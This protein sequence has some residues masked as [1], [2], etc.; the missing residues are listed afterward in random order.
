MDSGGG[1][2][3]SWTEIVLTFLGW[4]D[5]MLLVGCL[6]IGCVLKRPWMMMLFAILLSAVVNFVRNPLVLLFGWEWL[7][8]HAI[9]AMICT[10][11]VFVIAD[12]ARKYRA[13][14][15]GGSDVGT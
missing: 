8:G 15:R 11:L 5:P 12:T 1:E 13:A 6:V 4:T 10:T 14:H 9:G 3:H 7:L 2:G